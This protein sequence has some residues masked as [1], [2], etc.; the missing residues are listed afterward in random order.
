MKMVILSS[1]L[2]MNLKLLSKLN[3][4]MARSYRKYNN[5][6][7]YNSRVKQNMQEQERYFDPD[8]EFQLKGLKLSGKKRWKKN[9]AV[10]FDDY[11]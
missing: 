2:N 8:L 9:L 10:E 1:N 11:E 6:R 4:N 5:S 3:K 7:S